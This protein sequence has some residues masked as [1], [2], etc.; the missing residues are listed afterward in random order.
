MSSCI[1]KCAVM[2]RTSQ[3]AQ[4]DQTHLMCPA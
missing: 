2:T 1:H 3:T 4:T